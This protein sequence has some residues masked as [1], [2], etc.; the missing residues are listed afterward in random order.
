MDS[1]AGG[2]LPRTFP[3]LNS[4]KASSRASILERPGQSLLKSSTALRAA[5]GFEVSG[6]ISHELGCVPR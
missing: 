1:V 5:E 6:V 4:A 2:E 3:E